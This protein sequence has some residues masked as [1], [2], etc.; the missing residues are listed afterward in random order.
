MFDS[1]SVICTNMPTTDESDELEKA[2]VIGSRLL[3][4]WLWIKGTTDAIL[5]SRSRSMEWYMLARM[6]NLLPP[7][8]MATMTAR[9]R[10]YHAV[11]LSRIVRLFNLIL[12]GCCIRR[13]A[14]YAEDGAGPGDRLSNAGN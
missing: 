14:R 12:P 9:L 2:F 8:R 11:S 1:S 5:Y 4:E 10:K 6:A 7:A 13:R 3:S